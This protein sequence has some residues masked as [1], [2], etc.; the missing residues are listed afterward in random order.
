MDS[1]STLADARLS[2]HLGRHEGDPLDRL[3]AYG[4]A[5]ISVLLP[6]TWSGRYL[7]VVLCSCLTLST[8]AQQRNTA[9]GNPGPGLPARAQL[10]E[11]IAKLTEPP[12]LTNPVLKDMAAAYGFWLGQTYSI[13]ELSKRYP[14]LQSKFQTPLSNFNLKYKTGLTNIERIFKTRF[15][16]GFEKTQAAIL[17]RL[18]ATNLAHVSQQDALSFLQQMTDRSLNPLPSPIYETI[19]EFTPEFINAPEQEFSEGFKKTYSTANDPAALGIDLELKYPASWKAEPGNRPNIIQMMTS[20]NGRGLQIMNIVVLE[21]TPQ[22]QA[23]A[24]NADQKALLAETYANMDLKEM[25]PPGAT[26]LEGK[27]AMLDTQPAALIYYDYTLARV[28]LLLTMR[29][30]LLSTIYRGKG[31][32][33]TFL[34][35]T[36]LGKEETRPAVFEKFRPLFWQIAN[37]VVLKNTQ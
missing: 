31:L 6:K 36:E 16:S 17:K 10:S 33:L 14:N 27:T 19:L 11:Q 1:E 18:T 8:P 34:A 2:W 22:E 24:A 13:G 23:I 25:A 9:P 26:F 15:P 20:E 28:D 5:V 12:T 21:M 3:P 30:M 32:T 29:V 37:S 7:I 4:K 35:G